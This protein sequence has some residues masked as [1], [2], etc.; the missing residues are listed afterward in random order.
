MQWYGENLFRA[1]VP[2]DAAGVEVCATDL[3][4]NRTCARV[5]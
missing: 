3:A 1:D 5:E 4:G 2:P